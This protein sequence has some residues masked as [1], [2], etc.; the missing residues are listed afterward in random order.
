MNFPQ[1]RR[2]RNGLS[3]FR[4]LNES[5]FEEYKLFQGKVEKYLFKASILPDRN[6]IQDML[7]NYE[8]HWE[9]VSEENFQTFITTYPLKEA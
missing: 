8:E 9:E 7:H 1:Y 2:Y 6:F 4:I 5:S 3:Y